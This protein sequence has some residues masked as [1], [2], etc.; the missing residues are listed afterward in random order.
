VTAIL[1]S[2]IDA[3]SLAN[4]QAGFKTGG[5]RYATDVPLRPNF[6]TWTSPP[7]DQ[8]NVYPLQFKGRVARCST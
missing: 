6:A 3:G 8:E 7:A 2:L 4:L 5:F 1:R